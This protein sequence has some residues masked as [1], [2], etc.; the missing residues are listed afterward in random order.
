MSP[1]CISSPFGIRRL[2]GPHAALFHNGIDF[3]AP[4][5]A[6]VHAAA[7][8]NVVAVR[9]LGSSGLEIDLLHPPAPGAAAG[10]LTRYAHLGIVAPA[11]ANGRREVPAGGVIGRVGRT[12]ITYGTHVHLELHLAGQAVDPEPFF[13]ISRCS[14]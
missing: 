11:I 5:G 1:A 12:G 2:V 9:R 3:P 4:A 13:H 7:A 8:G 10:Y 6:W 14:R